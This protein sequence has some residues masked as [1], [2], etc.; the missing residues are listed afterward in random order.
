MSPLFQFIKAVQIFVFFLCSM[1]MGWAQAGI[2]MKN[3]MSVAYHEVTSE[4]KP[5]M[6]EY[7]IGPE[8]LQQHLDWLAQNG[9]QFIGCQ[10]L[11]EAQQRNKALP[12]KSV[13]L[14]FDDG[15]QSF[16]QHV[17]P[18]LKQ[19]NIPA[20]L[21]VVGRWLEPGEQQQVNFGGQMVSRQHFLT[22]AQLKE[23]QASGLVEIASHSYDLHKGIVANPQGNELPATVAR[24]YFPQQQRYENDNAY[25][26]RI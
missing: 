12:E 7:A 6:P 23:M 10:Q 4:P 21:S 5:L 16:Y 1:L 24:A 3:L 2:E 11:L 15:Y 19:R 18:I 13:L 22:W 8:Q 17:Y 25:Q 20:V 14:S 26:K 9:F